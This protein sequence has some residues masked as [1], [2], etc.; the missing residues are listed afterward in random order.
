[1]AATSQAAPGHVH[2]VSSYVAEMKATM[3]STTVTS[4]STTEDITNPAAAPISSTDDD[5]A[6]TELTSTVN[7]I[8]T[9]ATT[10]TTTTPPETTALVTTASTTTTEATANVLS[11]GFISVPS[12]HLTFRAS[13]TGSS[14]SSA[15][16]I[17][18]ENSGHLIYLNT[19]AKQ[20]YI[21]DHLSNTG[22]SAEFYIGAFLHNGVTPMWMDGTTIVNP[23]W[24]PNEPHNNAKCISMIIPSGEWKDDDCT[25]LKQ[26]I[27]EK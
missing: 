1:M 17:C 22:I 26:Y 8:T 12:I 14:W 13:S 18:G 24:A 7:V 10:A 16:T 5:E 4:E 21:I 25:V 3:S 19:A 2:Y 11:D 6:T 27:C 9:E 23:P 20:T 15:R